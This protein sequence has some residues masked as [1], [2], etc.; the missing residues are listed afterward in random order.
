[1][2]SS[3]FFRCAL[4]TYAQL[5][6]LPYNLL[7]QKTGALFLSLAFCY[8][9]LPKAREA[10]G[11]DLTDQIVIIDEAHS[12]LVLLPSPV[13]TLIF[14]DLIPTLLSLSTAR[15]PFST[16]STSLYQVGTYVAK[17]RTKLS[18]TNLLHLK[19]LVMVLEALKK[20]VLEWKE[21][22]VKTGKTRVEVM[23]VVELLNHL[24]RNVSNVNLLEIE[25]YLKLSKVH[26]PTAA[27]A[28]TDC[29]HRSRGK[30]PVIQI[31]RRRGWVGS[32]FPLR[33]HG[34][35][36]PQIQSYGL[37]AEQFLHFTPWRHSFCR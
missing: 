31:R 1:M 9:T 32:H 27:Y 28:S 29:V 3:I 6:T 37:D 23:T 19:R 18:S 24:G 8:S 5:I 33:Y 20:Y 4:S 14:L 26:F 13:I 34:P 2:V 25:G 36:V 22:H 10:L 7:L 21:D 15:L 11:I 17:F 35:F 30:L 16:L 12:V